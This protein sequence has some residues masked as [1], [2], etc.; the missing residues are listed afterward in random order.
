MRY[1]N[2]RLLYFTLLDPH[3]TLSEYTKDIFQSCFYYIHAIFKSCFYHIHSL[4][5]IPGSLDY[6]MIR[7]ITAALVTSTLDYVTLSCMA[8]PQSISIASSL[9]KISL[10][11]LLLVI[12][13]LALIWLLSLIWLL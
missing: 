3:I 12:V 2:P 5:H 7:T 8:F 6:S 4:R 13:L 1:T 10:H 9:L 11:E